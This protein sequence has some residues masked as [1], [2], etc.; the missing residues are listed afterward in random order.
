MYFLPVSGQISTLAV[1]HSRMSCSHALYARHQQHHRC[2]ASNGDA[3]VQAWDNPG[4]TVAAR[5]VV[6]EEGL[7]VHNVVAPLPWH[8]VYQQMPE[9]QRLSIDAENL[10]T[11]VGIGRGADVESY[12]QC[13][14]AHQPEGLR[15]F[16]SSG[17]QSS[18]TAVIA[19]STAVCVY[20]IALT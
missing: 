13:L 1:A 11:V 18:Q 9:D 8:W 10:R 2:V 3:L 20:E 17:D 6:D 15:S 4:A 7:V 5:E 16:H 19:M 12:S 14:V